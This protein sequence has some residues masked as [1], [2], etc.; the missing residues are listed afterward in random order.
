MCSQG[1]RQRSRDKERKMN[2]RAWPVRARHH[3]VILALCLAAPMTVYAQCGAQFEPC[4]TTGSPCNSP[5]LECDQ[6]IC[7]LPIV[8]CAPG[9]T[10]PTDTPAATATPTPTFTSTIT[11]TPTLT[12]TPT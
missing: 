2:T 10:C 4:C 11:P 8:V 3:L 1:F 12:P 9:L 6:G 5:M 7:M